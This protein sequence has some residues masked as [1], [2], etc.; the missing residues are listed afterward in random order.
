MTIAPLSSPHAFP[1]ADG[2]RDAALAARLDR[3]W[4]APHTLFGWFGTV[5]HKRIGVRYLVTAVALLIVGG[6]E[7]LLMRLQLI[8]PERRLLSPEAYNQ[9]FT[10]HGMTMI[11]WYAA[12]V[13]SG[14]GN[15]LVPLL[16]GSRDMAFPRLNA[17]SYWMYLCSGLLLYGSVLFG[18]APDAGWFAYVPLAARR[19]DAGLNMDFYPAAILALTLSTTAGAI[20]FLVTIAKH[21]APG[22]SLGRMPLFLY[23]TGTTAVLSLLALP[24]LTVACVFLELD[25]RWGTHFFTPDGGGAPLLWQHLFWFFGHPWVYIVFLPATGMVSML[26]PVYARRPIVGYKL[27]A[28]STVLTGLVGLSVWVHHMFAVGMGGAAMSFFSAASMTISL[29]STIQ[30]SCWV[31]TLW[32]GKPVRT[33]S[34]WF[35]LGFIATFVIGGLSGVVTAVIPFDWQVHDTYFVVAHLHYVLI[36]ANVFPVFAGLYHWWPKLTGRLADEAAGKLG[37]WMMFVGFNLGFFPMHLSGLLGMRRRVYTYG[38]DEGLA[39]LNYISTLGALLLAAGTLVTIANLVWSWRRGRFAG[40]DPWGADTL[41]W[42]I[43]SPPPSYGFARIPTV[44]SRHPLWDEHDEYADPRRERELAEGRLT[45]STSPIDAKPRA[46][47]AG[48]PESL[49]PLALAV[50]IT[51]V[52]AA[53]VGSGVVVALALVVVVAAIAAAWLW[54]RR[55][56]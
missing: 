40:P 38:A 29:F 50:A 4:S 3:L 21:R 39:T 30:I 49:A 11:L 1:V 16:M 7:A 8:G 26:L 52:F 51:A 35:A 36:G 55:A 9:L 37:F 54:P 41:E 44:T 17:F 48:E 25:R 23:S 19:Y 13:L 46:I 24:A 43:P 45:L 34:L 20:N 42:S 28:A 22:M 14:F 12:P 31:A 27:V 18:Q 5:D 53:L 32:S 6:L 10:M 15:Y 47:T 33:T 2:E 56:A